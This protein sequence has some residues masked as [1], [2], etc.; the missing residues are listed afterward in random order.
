MEQR[1]VGNCFLSYIPLLV[2]F[3]SRRACVRHP[4]LRAPPVVADEAKLAIDL[5]YF[6]YSRD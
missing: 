5:T 1:E 4:C 3:W 2:A 6:T